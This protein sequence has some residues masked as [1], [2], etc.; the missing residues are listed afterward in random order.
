MKSFGILGLLL[1]LL[2]ACAP[3]EQPKAEPTVVPVEKIKLGAIL[4]L[5]GD[6]AEYGLPE[7]AGIEI[8]VEEINS[9]GGV[10]GKLLEVIF[11]DSKCDSKAATTATQKLVD[12]DGVKVIIGG[13]CSSETIAAAAIT[14]PKQVVLLSPSASNPSIT[15]IGD[16]VFRTYPSDAFSA[17]VAAEHAF[18]QGWKKSAIISEQ[19]DY[20]Q[21]LRN[22]FK[23]TYNRLGGSVV[24]DETFGP[25]DTD[26]KTQILKI[27][28]AK[29]DV[30][31]VYPQTAAKGILI[32]KQLRELGAKQQLIGAEILITPAAAKENADLLEGFI[33]LEPAFDDKNAKAASLFG[34]Y[35]ARKNE[36]P[37]QPFFMASA[38]DDVYLVAEAVRANNGVVD[39][40][41]IRD[42]LYAVKDWDGAVGKLTI[43]QN[44]DPI[45]TFA[46]KQISNGV[47]LELK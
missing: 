10:N 3:A 35:K 40:V 42:F 34:K 28:R 18:K 2:V 6:A 37:P 44:G 46:I 45:M 7:K 24:A 41:Q 30:I 14:E 36:D 5:T 4:P 47:P 43:D 39:T 26:F 9:A 29:P 27:V 23:E 32:I 22:T 19:K 16:F 11:E 8:A 1:V 21:G 12:V 25:D 38:Y 20:A 31:A 17:S 15:T 13:A 33:G